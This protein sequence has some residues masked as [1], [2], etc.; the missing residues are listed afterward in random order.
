MLIIVSILLKYTDLRI[1][2]L[3]V[4]SL[5]FLCASIFVF[6]YYYSK[7]NIRI[8]GFRLIFLF[9]LVCIGSIF[10]PT[11]ML[12]YNIVNMLTYFVTA[13]VGAIICF[14]LSRFLA[15]N[16]NYMKEKL[17][18]IGN[19]TMAILVWHF[20]CFK[21]VSLLIIYIYQLPIQRLAEFPVIADY[22]LH[23]W[24]LVYMVIGVIIPLGIDY[25]FSILKG[26]FNLLC[27]YIMSK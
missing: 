17:I 21:L 12:E 9:I 2:Y 13:I 23:G 27:S 16:Y 15:N 22:A 19:H 11:T 8:T 10:W 1:P 5:S 14:E 7:I 24:W 18:Y 25:M 26:H 6:G 3:G 20:L 4:N